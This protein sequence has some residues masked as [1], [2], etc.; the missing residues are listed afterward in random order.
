MKAPRILIAGGE[1]THESDRARALSRDVRAT[2]IVNVRI[3]PDSPVE[4]IVRKIVKIVV[5]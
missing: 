2:C 5:K 4:H 1:E 3:H